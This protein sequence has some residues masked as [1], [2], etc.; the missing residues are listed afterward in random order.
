LAAATGAA[1]PWDVGDTGQP[2]VDADFT[3]TEGTWMSVDVSPD[4]QTLAFDLLGDI[5]TI[6]ASGGD[7][8]L[9]HGGAAMQRDPRF[10]PDGRKLLYISDASGGDNAW[11]SNADGSEE[12]QITSETVNS[13][14]GPTWGPNGEF[15]AAAR[16]FSSDDKLHAAELRLFDLAGGSGRL[17]VAAPANGENV[18]EPQ[19]SRDG[20][21]LYYTEKVS[22]P[23]R[24]VV[25]IDANH[26]HYAIMRR[27]LN[28]GETEELIKGFGSA[29]TPELS[30]DGK[31]IAFIRRVK[32]KTVL[33]LYDIASGEQRPVFAG[34]DRDAQAD[35]TWQG[36]YYPQYDW[37]NDSRHVAIWGQGK[38]WNVDMDGGSAVEIP[39]RVHAKHRITTPP[40]FTY[41][42]APKTFT[43]RAIRQLAYSPDGGTVVFN[44]LGRLWRKSAPAAKPV[45]LTKSTSLEFEPS[46]SSDGR[47][48]A[49]VEWSDERGGALKL[50]S[51]D[52]SSSKTLIT[53]GGVLRSPS[54]SRDGTK[55]VY[56]IDAG[57]RCLGGHEAR[58]GT[59]WVDVN[60]GE[61]HYVTVPG[62]APVFSPD[63]KR[64]Y[65]SLEDYI[66]R[67][68]RGRSGRRPQV[69]CSGRRRPAGSRCVRP[70]RSD[71]NRCVRG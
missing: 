15:I 10:S 12:R 59:Y 49:Y 20:R 8:K 24:A 67:G 45:R 13:I 30:P 5:Y 44:A 38:L 18:H 26:I 56:K 9:V 3:V 46:F 64:I 22:P 25:Y 36:I 68:W 1:A 42:L 48:I 16:L 66:G 63:G 34:L 6:A 61:S 37:F 39:F 14:T 40:R 29:T 60:G 21:Y 50:I 17:L 57:D 23:S 7:A 41:E 65:Y 54:F 32:E 33:F 53:S 69:P 51:A 58:V 31:R 4:G 52:G 11:M 62:A 55:L 27:D 19:F 2:F 43:V 28:T 71:R 70:F 47:K 35:F